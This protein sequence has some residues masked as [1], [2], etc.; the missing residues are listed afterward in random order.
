[1][2]TMRE[3]LLK[4]REDMIQL[5][6]G[7]VEDGGGGIPP[8][9]QVIEWHEIKAIDAALSQSPIDGKRQHLETILHNAAIEEPFLH[10]GKWCISMDGALA[11]MTA[12]ISQP[13]IDDAA[14]RG[15]IDDRT[16]Q[17]A[18]AGSYSYD[19]G[20][21]EAAGRVDQA[22]GLRDEA[23]RLEGWANYLETYSWVAKYLPS[24]E[25]RLPTLEDRIDSAYIKGGAHAVLELMAK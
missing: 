11:G 2:S 25:P 12:V 21:E 18:A 15:N 10:N 5:I 9:E 8:I 22:K 1:M 20:Y 23:S 7:I 4:A 16:F 6:I 13:S 17:D 14:L 24:G 19:A 3:A